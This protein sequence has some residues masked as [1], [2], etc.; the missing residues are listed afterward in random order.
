MKEKRKEKTKIKSKANKQTKT[1]KVRGWDRSYSESMR[2]KLFC[3]A[4]KLSFLQ[5]ICKASLTFKSNLQ[6]DL[7]IILNQRELYESNHVTV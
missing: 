4:F 2:D 5:L 7:T 1:E 6:L 3:C